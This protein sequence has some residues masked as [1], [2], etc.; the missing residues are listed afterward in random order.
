M[1]MKKTLFIALAFVF[2]LLA[3]V[4]PANAQIFAGQYGPADQLLQ[5]NLNMVDRW[6][7]YG[8]MYGYTR[9]GQFYGMYDRFGRR[10]SRPVRIAIAGAEIGAT[11]GAMTGH[12]W[13]GT[14]IGAGIGAAPG[15][16]AWA[17]SKRGDDDDKEVVVDLPDQI[18]P[19]PQTAQVSSGP[20]REN[21]WN[22][23]LREQANS[24]GSLF[25]S[26]RG[27]L[28]Q[29][30]ATLK[31]EGRNP[32]QV[33]QN[34]TWYVDLLPRQSEC[35]DPRASYEAEVL[36]MVVDGFS[37]TADTVRT[38]PEGRDGLVLVWR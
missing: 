13:K 2:A 16:L 1:R 28:E 30:M 18:P 35:G 24:G 34:G 29:G 23:R 38:K 27:C 3:G 21:G 6:M 4:T 33:Y 31:N 8:D 25:G 37:G 12:G 20:G 26:H 17:F 32:M 9:G 15:L 11:I 10:L 19:M 22:P 14:A 7:W 5:S 36:S